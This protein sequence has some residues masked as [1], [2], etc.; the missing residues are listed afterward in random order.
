MVRKHDID[1]ML[2]KIPLFSACSARHLAEIT[3]NTV[4]SSYPAGTVIARQGEIGREFLVIVEGNA[5]VVLDGETIATLGP[6]DFFGEIAL[7][8]GGPRTATVT[9]ETDLVVE[10]MSHAEFTAFLV[11]VPELTRSIL[12]GVAAR[13]RVTDARLVH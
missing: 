10:V 8:D 12:K 3:R 4:T 9:A 1:P 7:L 2:A 5:S 11:E 13:L 6:G